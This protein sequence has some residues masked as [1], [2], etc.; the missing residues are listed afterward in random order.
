MPVLSDVSA[1]AGGALTPDA[2]ASLSAPAQRAVEVVQFHPTSSGLLLSNQSSD[3]QI[4]DIHAGKAALALKGAEKGH[5]SVGWS[6]D[7]RFVH[8]AGKDNTVSVWDVRNSTEK[9]SSVSLTRMT[10]LSSPQ[11]QVID[12]LCLPLAVRYRT[13]GLQ[14]AFQNHVHQRGP[15][16]YNRLLKDEGSRM[17]ALGCT[18]LCQARLEHPARYQYWRAD[19]SGGPGSQDGLPHWSGEHDCYYCTARRYVYLSACPCR[20]TCLCDGSRSPAPAR[21]PRERQLSRQLPSGL[22]SCLLHQRRSM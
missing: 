21:L 5:W 6:S 2:V 19:A 4:W 17:L 8:T 16:P 12:R 7:G 9:A 22:P 14:Q 10:I 1:G 13:P 11:T 18:Q 15:Y 20:R 3:T